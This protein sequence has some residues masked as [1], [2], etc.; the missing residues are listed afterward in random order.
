MGLQQ[1]EREP[2]L[3]VSRV[4]FTLSDHS[5]AQA[6][7]QHVGGFLVQGRHPESRPWL[8]LCLWL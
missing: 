4:T 6:L 5:A 8:E 3:D 1:K 7:E 2:E